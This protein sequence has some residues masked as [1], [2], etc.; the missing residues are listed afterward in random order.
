MQITIVQ[1]KY[2][3]SLYL[4]GACIL[5]F[6]HLLFAQNP[7]DSLYQQLK[8]TTN[9]EQKLVLLNKLSEEVGKVSTTEALN[10]ATD[11]EQLANLLHDS[12]NLGRALN[13]LTW[14]LLKKGDFTK[15]FNYGVQAL[16]VNQ[17][18]H[19]DPQL[20]TSYRN[21][22]G[23]Y[24]SQGNYALSTQCLQKDLDIN[25]RLN[26]NMGISRAYNNLAF[27][28][29][30]NGADKKANDFVKKAMTH[31][32]KIADKSLYAFALRT[33]GDI[34]EKKGN[35]DS[36][37][38]YYSESIK[39]SEISKE[40]FTTVTSMYRLGKVYLNQEKFTEALEMF[41]RALPISL[42]YG[43]NNLNS[44]I[45]KYK[46]LT[47]KGM[48]DYQHA[49]EAFL[50]YSTLNEALFEEKERS[51]I[52][53]NQYAFETGK[54]KA[55]IQLLK[56]EK[57]LEEKQIQF[58]TYLNISFVITI[59]IIAV[60]L[61]IIW[62]KNNLIKKSNQLLTEQK[63]KLEESSFLKDKIFSIISHDL[64]SPIAALTSALPM[65]D[66]EN[67]DPELFNSIK[68]GLGKQ[69]SSLSFTID[70]LLIWARSQMKGITKPEY[71]HFDIT[72][73]AEHNCLLLQ[74]LAQQKS[75]QLLCNLQ[76]RSLVF[77]DKQQID[78]LIRNLLLNAIKFTKENGLIEVHASETAASIVLMVTDN[79]I[80][81]SKEQVGNLFNVKTHFTTPGTQKE[82]GTGLGLL[83]CMEF[84]LANKGNLLV[85]SEPG[86][87]TSISLILPKPT[88]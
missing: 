30:R 6:S 70:N 88:I 73:V 68:N 8:K 7:T 50:Q 23:V 56:R 41:D 48:G 72:M 42:K 17:S 21:I 5:L 78:I 76:E 59:L 40:V 71:T 32:I 69:L 3:H 11:A 66:Q 22:A 33:L 34:F 55:E 81:M 19:H 60:M 67:I 14:I 27:D 36:A 82:K 12:T 57:E 26:D 63:Q 24:Y 75:I 87:G 79:G 35:Y 58:Q 46:A 39:W 13:N 52:A 61:G 80:G 16:S 54:N 28:A 18:I 37:I 86:E 65:L 10:Y 47:F 64:R 38:Y 20:A 9:N 4:T 25:I 83:I 74:A 15:A 77:A 85:E 49:Y 31:S 29:F 62:R 43:S 53:Q 45:Y 84:A 51:T 2:F 1:K 44:I